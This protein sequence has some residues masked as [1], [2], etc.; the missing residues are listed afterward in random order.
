MTVLTAHSRS[1][2]I[3]LCSIMS[4]DLKFKRS[5]CYNPPTRTIY[6]QGRVYKSQYSHNPNPNSKPRSSPGIQHLENLKPSFLGYDRLVYMEDRMS[7]DIYNTRNL[8]FLDNPTHGPYIVRLL[9]YDGK[10]VILEDNFK[11]PKFKSANN[12]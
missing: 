7:R 2:Y 3:F 9:A 1:L 5:N 11:L 10:A 8:S 4:I 6:N 12:Q